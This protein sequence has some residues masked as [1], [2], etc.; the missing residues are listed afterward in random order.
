[1]CAIGKHGVIDVIHQPGNLGC[2][3]RC[4]LLYLL[5]RVLFIAGIDALGGVSGKEVSVV[6]QSRH[7]LHHGQALLFGDSGIHRTLIHHH[8]ATAYHLAHG[9]AGTQ[10]RGEVGMVVAVNGSGYG[11]H[12]EVA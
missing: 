11:H 8:V 6:L 1:M 4:D 3:A 5:Y 12:V 2:G 10:Q 9:A 7:L